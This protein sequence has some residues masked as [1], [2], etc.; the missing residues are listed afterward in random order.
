[1]CAA[2]VNVRTIECGVP[3]QFMAQWAQ[4]QRGVTHSQL[5]ALGALQPR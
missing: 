5:V 2:T 1:M 3:D 4:L